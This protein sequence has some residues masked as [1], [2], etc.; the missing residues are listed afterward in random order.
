MSRRADLPSRSTVQ[1]ALDELLDETSA[2]GV[3]PTVVSL[4]RRLGLANTTFWR[5]FP[6]LATRSEKTPGRHRPHLRHPRPLCA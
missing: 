1:R 5:H 6:D 4:A 3:R 2:E